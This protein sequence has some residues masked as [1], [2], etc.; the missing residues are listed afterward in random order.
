MNAT[1]ECHFQKTKQCLQHTITNNE[2]PLKSNV[3][4]Y[5]FPFIDIDV[6]L[7][8]TGSPPRQNL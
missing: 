5:R 8:G 2:L 7:R 1:H 3:T 6:I 4:T